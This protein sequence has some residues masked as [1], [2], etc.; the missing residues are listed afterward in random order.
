MRLIH[1]LPLVAGL[2]LV[3][4]GDSGAVED[5]SDPE[6]IAAATADLPKPLAGEYRMTGELVELAVPGASDE[7]IQMIR[8]IM[9]MAATQER[10]FCMTQ[11]EADEGY[12]EFLENL[13]EGTDECEFS[14]FSV[15]G[16]TLAAT[17]QCDD[18]A[19]S[20]GTMEFGGNISE[21][22]QDM[23]VTMDMA[24]AEE[25]DS[26]RMVLRNQTERIG[27]CAG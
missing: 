2:A 11:E 19:G 22:S 27:D 1:T 23:T 10:T 7:E 9:E 15:N 6:Q 12:R 24:N 5:P 3:A 21:T 13:S 26:M 17:M 8:G 20:T 18:G 4:C 25:G 16:N 14:E